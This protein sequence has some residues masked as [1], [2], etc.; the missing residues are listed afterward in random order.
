[1][2]RSA[3]YLGMLAAAAVFGKLWSF[4]W[5]IWSWI[6]WLLFFS[7]ARGAYTCNHWL[8]RSADVYKWRDRE[9]AGRG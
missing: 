3:C 7:L 6:G 5:A 8:A 4:I 1:V 2:L 9:Y